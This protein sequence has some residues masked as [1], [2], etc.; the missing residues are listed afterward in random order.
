MLKFLEE[1][2]EYF[3]N[4]KKENSNQ[5]SE[6]TNKAI[7]FYQREIKEYKKGLKNV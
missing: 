2:L 1:N 7:K 6:E 3:I 5:F 4:W